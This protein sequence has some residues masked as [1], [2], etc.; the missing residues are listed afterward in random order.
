M[1][2]LHLFFKNVMFAFKCTSPSARIFVFSHHVG[3]FSPATP[4]RPLTATPAA[5]PFPAVTS[6][7]ILVVSVVVDGLPA[8][9]W[10]NWFQK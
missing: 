10:Y 6:G 3:G 9:Y 4:P 5:T 1:H 7:Q 8:F 2:C